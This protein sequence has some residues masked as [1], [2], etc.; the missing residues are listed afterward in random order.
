M[1]HIF[2]NNKEPFGSHYYTVYWILCALYKF[3]Y[4]QHLGIFVVI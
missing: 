3:H 4:F 1:I 2:Y